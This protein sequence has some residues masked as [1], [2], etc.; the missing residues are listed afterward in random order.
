MRDPRRKEKKI[1]TLP[2]ENKEV[3]QQ[4]TRGKPEIFLLTKTMS[5]SGP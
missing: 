2:R 5:G 3:S 1:G 4:I